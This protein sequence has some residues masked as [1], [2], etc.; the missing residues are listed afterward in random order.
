MATKIHPV[1]CLVLFFVGAPLG[2]IIRKGGLGLP[3]VVSVILFVMYHILSTTG[4]KYA[5]EGVLSPFE[6]MWLASAVFLP[7]GIFLTYKATSDSPLMDT[8][9]WKKL[10]ERIT[11]V[12]NRNIPSA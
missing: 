4:F 7:I 2:A 5:R 9:S 10:F 6:G 12:F 3:L 11:S 8:D 1:A